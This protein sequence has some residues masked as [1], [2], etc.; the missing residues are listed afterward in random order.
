MV[1]PSGLRDRLGNGPVER[2][3]HRAR[4]ALREMGVDLSGAHIAVP[5]LFLHGA[6]VRAAGEQ[7]SGEALSRETWNTAFD[8]STPMVVAFI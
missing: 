4:A 8:R 5:K 3:D 7:V 1:E 2:T 6:Y